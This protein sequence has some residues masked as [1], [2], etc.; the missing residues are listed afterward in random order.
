MCP[1]YGQLIIIIVG[2]GAG[3]FMMNQASVRELRESNDGLKMQL[4]DVIAKT[5]T[6]D[7]NFKVLIEL[8]KA[9]E[10]PVRK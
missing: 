3:L 1:S 7:D 8:M 9:P 2:M 5:K 4:A 10:T 6:L